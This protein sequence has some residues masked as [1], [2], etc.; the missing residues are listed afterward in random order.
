V[1]E[2]HNLVKVRYSSNWEEYVD[3]TTLNDLISSKEIKELYRPSENRWVGRLFLATRREKSLYPGQERRAFNKKIL[4][5]KSRI[6]DGYYEARA[7][8]P[9]SKSGLVD[10]YC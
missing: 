10:I 1:R 8:H 5:L 3:D 6:P 9:S 4:F 7:R 2:I